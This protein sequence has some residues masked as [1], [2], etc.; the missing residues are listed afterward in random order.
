VEIHGAHGYLI[1]QF[2]SLKTNRRTDAYGGDHRGRIKFA[3]EVI[4]AV[5]DAVGPDFVVGIRIS[6]DPSTGGEY[7]ME[8]TRIFAELLAQNGGLDYIATGAG[9][10]SVYAPQGSLMYASK[11]MKD[12]SGLPVIGGG[13]IV[14]PD[15]AEKVLAENQADLV[16]MN[17]AL[18]CDPEMPNKAREGRLE[19]IRRCM[20]CSEG[21]YAL[22]RTGASFGRTGIA[23]SFNPVVGRESEPGWL[24]LMPAEKKKKVMVIGGGPG[25]LETARIAKLRGHDVSLWEKGEALG[26]MTLIGAEAPARKDLLEVKRYYAHQMKLLDVDVR[27]NSP[28]TVETVQ[29]QNPD[30]VVVATGSKPMAPAHIPGMDQENVI[31]NV[32]DVLSGKA[33]TGRT[34]LI[35][36]N[37][38]HLEGLVAADFLAS[39]GKRVE[40]A[41][42]VETPG[43]LVENVTRMALC[44][45]LEAAGVKLRPRT[46]I[47]SIAGNSVSLTSPA[48][49][50]IG[51]VEVDT[52]VL[53]FGGVEDNELYYSLKRKFPEVYAVGDCNGV[54]RRLWAVNDGA[55]IGR[56]I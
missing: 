21:C 44:Q 42:P 47:R 36:D 3:S 20:G 34:V 23:C 5:R 17:R 41:Y 32:R 18:I 14:D 49:E 15:Y 51:E 53:S 19:E 50:D 30:V 55:E 11:M 6:V 45:R 33:D 29:V 4:D 37:Q 22:G 46:M 31:D 43:A 54:R 12:A 26:G 27:L 56:H 52:V 7:T 8:D 48:G 13:R 40:L 2:M 38:W 24:E 16:Y 28:V 9:T 35:L 25:G 39:R 10:P 1:S